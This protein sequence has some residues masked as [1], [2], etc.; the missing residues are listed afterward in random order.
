MLGVEVSN[1][2]QETFICSNHD[3]WN[4]HQKWRNLRHGLVHIILMVRES[5]WAIMDRNEY[6]YSPIL[7]VDMNIF[8]TIRHPLAHSFDLV[9]K[10]LHENKWDAI[11]VLLSVRVQSLGTPL[12]NYDH[13]FMPQNRTRWEVSKAISFKYCDLTSLKR[14]AFFFC[15][16]LLCRNSSVS[17]YLSF[18]F[19]LPSSR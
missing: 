2:A 13:F 4:A 3:A 7:W 19:E 16:L 14:Q 17:L 18:S 10:N 9:S 1:G 11:D 8:H 15:V 12:K 5:E 6:A